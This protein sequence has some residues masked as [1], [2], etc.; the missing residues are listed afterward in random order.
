MLNNIE[1]LVIIIL[2]EYLLECGLEIA[3]IWVISEHSIR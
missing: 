2:F 1:K 3:F